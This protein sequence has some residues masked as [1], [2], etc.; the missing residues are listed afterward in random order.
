VY[1]TLA[2][3]LH[4]KSQALALA[5]VLGH[6]CIAEQLDAYIF[7]SILRLE[8][9]QQLEQVCVEHLALGGE[10]DALG[11][12]AV[13]HGIKTAVRLAARGLGP[14]RLLEFS[15]F[16]SSLRAETV[17]GWLPSTFS[18]APFCNLCGFFTRVLS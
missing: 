8:T 11:A 16:D 5:P 14:G 2:K 7:A 15:R 9:L 12:Q 18:A 6:D 13:L 1:V 10:D 4:F 3:E 17:E